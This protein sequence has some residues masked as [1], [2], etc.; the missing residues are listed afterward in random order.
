MNVQVVNKQLSVGSIHV[1]AV[2]GASVIL[3]GDTDS[4]C[5]SSAFDTPPESYIVGPLA[6]LA[7]QA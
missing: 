2:V 6:P 5:L 1:T 7:P 3:V 4:I